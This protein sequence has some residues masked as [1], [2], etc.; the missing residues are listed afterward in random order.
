MRL[1]LNF[2]KSLCARSGD[3]NMARSLHKKTVRLSQDFG[4]ARS[5][6]PRAGS[7]AGFRSTSAVQD[8]NIESAEI[9]IL[10]AQLAAANAKLAESQEAKSAS[11]ACLKALKEFMA[12]PG[13]I[14]GISLPP[15]PTDATEDT[16][17]GAQMTS[18][19]IARR[20]SLWN[21][22][23]FLK[24]EAE[25]LP[26][27]PALPS[28][29][30]N[31]GNKSDGESP[32]LS[33]FNGWSARRR[34][35]TVAAKDKA[36]SAPPSPKLNSTT[37]STAFNTFGG[38]SFQSRT[39]NPALMD[40][41]PSPGGGWSPGGTTRDT[42]PDNPSP[43]A[44]NSDINQKRSHALATPPFASVADGVLARPSS[45]RRPPLPTID[46]SSSATSV[47]AANAL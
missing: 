28:G 6:Q 31:Q 42:L 11:E 22:P 20:P 38:F 9:A 29:I 13:N 12:A 1:I 41:P 8:T 19:S 34:A 7:F 45:L 4:D 43:N 17:E 2:L 15:L 21:I 3:E 27:V 40:S 5:I 14:G 36:P 32:V 46:S 26:A 33:A 47:S 25:K 16:E 37:Q 44:F 23:A 18:E 30:N 24:S 10:K 35:S 39:R